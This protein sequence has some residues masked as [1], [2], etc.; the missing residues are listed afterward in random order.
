MNEE[1]LASIRDRKKFLEII[2]RRKRSWLG[3]ILRRYCLMQTTIDEIRKRGKKGLEPVDFKERRGYQ[4]K[5][6]AQD[7]EKW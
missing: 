1:V 6:D 2:C 4:L 5:K 3:H 7:L